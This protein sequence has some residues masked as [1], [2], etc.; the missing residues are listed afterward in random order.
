MPELY[1]HYRCFFK[2][3][4]NKIITMVIQLK[5]CFSE[6]NIFPSI[7]NFENLENPDNFANLGKLGDPKNHL[8]FASALFFCGGISR[9][10]FSC[11]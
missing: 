11:L 4:N 7:A 9:W 1:L 2:T 5:E 6:L 10:S 3:N 8:Y